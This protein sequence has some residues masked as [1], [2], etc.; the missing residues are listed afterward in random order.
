MSMRRFGR[1]GGL[2]GAF[3]LLVVGMLAV[4]AM[5]MMVFGAQV[6]RGTVDRAEAH[7]EARILRSVIRSAVWAEEAEG[8]VRVEELGGIPVLMLVNDS[9]DGGYVRCLYCSEG[10]LMEQL[11]TSLED[12]DPARGETLCALAG[13]EPEL[14]DGML[15]VTLENVAGETETVRLSL[16]TGGNAR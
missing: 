14:K 7:G 11:L 9:A 4:L 2:S 16:R 1:E 15:S 13:F 5:L 3:M 6:Y 8:A 12:F 10:Q